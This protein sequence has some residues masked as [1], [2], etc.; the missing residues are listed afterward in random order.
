MLN[1]F[2]TYLSELVGFGSVDL[3]STF[4]TYLTALSSYPV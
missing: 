3:V 2:L 1:I 4:G